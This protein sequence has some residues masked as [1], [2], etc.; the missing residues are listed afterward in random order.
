[1]ALLFKRIATAMWKPFDTVGCN[2]GQYQ[3]K[4]RISQPIG[5]GFHHPMRVLHRWSAARPGLETSAVAARSSAFCTCIT[6]TGPDALD[7]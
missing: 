2:A 6:H 7:D 5:V 3:S 4:F 1:M